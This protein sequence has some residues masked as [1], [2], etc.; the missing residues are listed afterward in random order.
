YGSG[1]FLVRLSLHEPLLVLQIENDESGKNQ[2]VLEKLANL[3]GHFSDLE[4]LSAE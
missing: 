2:L 1:W 4:S 3:F